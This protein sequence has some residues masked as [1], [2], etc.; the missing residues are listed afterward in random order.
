MSTGLTLYY[1]HGMLG[2]YDTPTNR[3]YPR[4]TEGAK[5]AALTMM[6]DLPSLKV[7]YSTKALP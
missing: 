7:W 1:L 3:S 4:G 5:L 2:D 6:V